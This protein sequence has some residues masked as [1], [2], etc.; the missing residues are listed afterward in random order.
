MTNTINER[1]AV[2]ESVCKR[3]ESGNRR[4]RYVAAGALCLALGGVMLGV[5]SS[6][7]QSAGSPGDKV[8]TPLYVQLVS[9]AV[10]KAYVNS[11]SNPLYVRDAGSG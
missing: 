1:V 11:G 3:L 5:Q 4:M 7:S 9:P 8:L 6:G 2:L 10:H